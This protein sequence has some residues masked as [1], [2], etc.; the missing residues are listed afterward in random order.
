MS[1]EKLPNDLIERIR[2]AENL[3]EEMSMKVQITP[4]PPEQKNLYLDYL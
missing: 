4:V 1:R 3:A 2:S